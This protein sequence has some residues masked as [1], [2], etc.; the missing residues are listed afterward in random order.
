MTHASAMTPFPS[1]LRG[2]PYIISSRHSK[3]AAEQGVLRTSKVKAFKC[4]TPRCRTRVIRAVGVGLGWQ[5][6]DEKRTG[7]FANAVRI[8]GDEAIVAVVPSCVQ[9]PMVFANLDKIDW[10]R[11]AGSWDIVL[12]KERSVSLAFVCAE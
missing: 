10:T 4:R 3:V 1:P 9:Q 11:D 6:V 7:G 8:M 5:S 12:L 2:L